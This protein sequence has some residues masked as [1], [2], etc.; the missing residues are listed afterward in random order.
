MTETITVIIPAYNEESSIGNVI[1]DL[2]DFVH[3]IIVV[4]NNSTDATEK[5]AKDAGAIVLT[6]L[7][8]GYGNACL[9][10]IEHIKQQKKK[11]NPIMKHTTSYIQHAKCTTDS[12]HCTTEHNIQQHTTAYNSI[13]QHTTAY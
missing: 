11:A 6:E 2:P 9:K 3:E 8:A 4:N 5:N 13:Q 1:R 10:G 12:I 7:K